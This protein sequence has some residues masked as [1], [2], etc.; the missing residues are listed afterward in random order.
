MNIPQDGADGQANAPPLL[1][2]HLEHL[3]QGSGLAF[4]VIAERGYR[5]IH[6][7]GSYSDLKPFGFSRTQA[8]LNPGI[9]LPV[10]STNGATSPVL[11]VY[12]PDT[13]REIKGRP[14][15]YEIPKGAGL[16]LDCPPRCR[17]MLQD[18]KIPL[19]LT[20]GQ[21]KGDALA[22]HGLC[23]VALLSVWA[24][25]GKNDFGAITFLNDWDYLS[26]QGREVRVV[27]DNDV[28]T[29]LSV[30]KA[31]ARLTE[32]LQR[33]GAYV[34]EV[35]LPQDGGRKVGV[36]D[37]LLQH[38]RDDLEGLIE[39]PRPTPEPAKPKIELLAAPPK[40]ITRPLT[41]INGQAYAAT[42]LWT[43]TTVT[44]RLGK[45]GEILKLAKPAVSETRHLFIVRDDGTIFAG[46]DDPKVKPLEE[47]GLTVHLPELPRDSRLWS[48]KGVMAY[49]FG[50]RPDPVDVLKKIVAVVNRFMDFKR[51]LASQETMC[52]LV[53]CYV[54]ATYAL[55]AFNVI[56]Y[57]WPNG[58][59]GAGKT[60]FLLI[61]CELAYLG[62]VILA[63]GSYA[64]LR[65]LADYG[66]TIAFDDAETV[67][68]L[69]RGDPDKRMLLLA[70]NRRGSQVTVRELTT[71]KTWR[72]RY[73]NTFAPRLFSAIRLPDDVLGS[74]T[75]TIPMV[76]SIDEDRAKA[77][78]LDHELWPHDH[79]AL[80]DDLWAL[81]LAHLPMI[82]QYDGKAAQQARLN[83]RD[84]EPWR[85]ILAVAAWLDSHDTAGEL[86]RVYD[87]PLRKNADNAE[88]AEMPKTEDLEG[89]TT[90]G[91]F[92]R[93]EAL[94]V[95]YQ[96]E[97]S[98]L[99]VQD[100]TR[101][102]ILA[103]CE[104]VAARFDGISAFEFGTSELTEQMNRLAREAELI[105][106][107]EEFT[108]T[109]RVGWLLKRLR[110]K[111]A[112]PGKTHRRW[113]LKV[114]EIE[115]LAR[116]YGMSGPADKNAKN[117][118]MQNV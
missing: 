51:S 56:A 113:A 67:M 99:E 86:Q 61:V 97:R 41:L 1:P 93:L 109:R 23:A 40:A 47:L 26:L 66:A 116:A 73:V 15:K 110:F 111:K 27:F 25:N 104:M 72:T 42:W 36:D 59:K 78:P 106:D 20:E 33:K 75:I 32:H 118:E 76:R 95:L 96:D 112:S 63:G 43:R 52:E 117:A 50:Y 17:A 35:Y 87:D 3:T 19:W 30:R 11:Y 7:P 114:A 108:N 45:D 77:D 39:Q 46:V 83:G 100:P 14:C 81:A 115:A 105:K 94:S 102:L 80:I 49:R 28:M 24:F 6:G 69:K 29:K 10:W 9:L 98:D 79:T 82:K 85:A 16:R 103:L 68:D 107:G 12:R 54:I 38:T 21:K 57:L 48:T 44:E 5:S 22:S 34:V 64:S 13:P 62:E 65:D 8:H 55:D 88:N 84:L 4:E 71:A 89:N 90:G 92:A 91:L 37:Y 60:T 2:H 74:R 31:L 18:P 101:L 58:D 70:G 53:A